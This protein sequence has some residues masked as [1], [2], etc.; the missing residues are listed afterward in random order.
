MIT[1]FVLPQIL[2][3]GDKVIELSAF[4][5]NMP[6][7]TTQRSGTMRIDGVVR[8]R[9]EGEVTGVVHAV[10]KGNIAA[11]VENGDVKMVSEDVPYYYSEEE[12]V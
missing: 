3:V 4:V 1:M 12:D 7:R 9:I 8:G 11:F 2:L 10:V 6:I 5:M